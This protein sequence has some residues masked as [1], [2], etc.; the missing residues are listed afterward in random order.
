MHTIYTERGD[1]GK[2]KQER[3]PPLMAKGNQI[4]Q[5]ERQISRLNI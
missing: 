5:K 3:Y 2:L 1:D 4:K